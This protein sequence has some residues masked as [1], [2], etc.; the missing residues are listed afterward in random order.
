MPQ[1]SAS[2]C[3][4]SFG[5]IIESVAWPEVGPSS[6]TLFSTTKHQKCYHYVEVDV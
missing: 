5:G 3:P 1:L 4:A 2:L 6:I